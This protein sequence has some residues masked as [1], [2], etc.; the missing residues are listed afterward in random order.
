MALSV[1]GA[2]GANMGIWF[3]EVWWKACLY[4]LTILS[5]IACPFSTE[6]EAAPV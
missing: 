4:Q 5:V 1:N 2:R 3:I 6:S